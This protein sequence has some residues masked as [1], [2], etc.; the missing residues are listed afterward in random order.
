MKEAESVIDKLLDWNE[1]TPEPTLS[2]IEKIVL[3]LRQQLSE[4]MAQE[5]VTSQEAKQPAVGP[6]CPKCRQAM[7]YKGQKRVTPQTW[8]GDVEIERG[9]YHCGKCKQGFF[10]PG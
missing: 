9:Y 8:V 10:P 3:E 2:Q 7:T 4:K 5:V 1:E 6:P